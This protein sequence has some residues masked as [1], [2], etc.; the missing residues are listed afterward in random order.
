LYP[1]AWRARYADELRVL[2]ADRGAGWHEVADLAQGCLSEWARAA[3]APRP[4]TVRAAIATTLPWLTA[5]VAGTV[6]FTWIA[7]AAGDALR[8]A[9][10]AASSAWVSTSFL[11]FVALGVR[12]A[13]A[14]FEAKPAFSL[15]RRIGT[16]E[17][18]G[19]VGLIFGSVLVHHWAGPGGLADEPHT[20]G[21]F[22]MPMTQVVL[23]FLASRR[24]AWLTLRQVNLFALR[25]I[26]SNSRQRLA[27][28]E[29]LARHGRARAEAL[30]RVRAEH[31]A[32][33]EPFTR[34]ALDLRTTV[35]S[36]PL[37]L[38]PTPAP[39]LR[40]ESSDP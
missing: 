34:A 29:R 12:V 15:R 6:A 4:G 24:Y 31:A 33:V 38:D 30:A 14:L 37:G 26:V 10:G 20:A 3:A 1:R 16:A 8:S 28:L 32:A 7:A 23:V 18:A 11:G 40:A 2:L 22:V 17:S 25:E 9:N 19:W 27:R 35:E 21:M 13:V 36:H 5:L 39:T